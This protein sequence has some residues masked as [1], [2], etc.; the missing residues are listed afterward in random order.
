MEKFG[1]NLEENV[2]G[3]KEGLLEA[4]QFLRMARLRL[5]LETIT[6]IVCS[7]CTHMYVRK[8]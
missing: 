4:I 8:K 5:K 2:K 6:I 7:E 1:L 3:S